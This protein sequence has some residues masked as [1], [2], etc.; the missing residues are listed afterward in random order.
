MKD[1]KQ[2]EYVSAEEAADLL[3]VS[4]PTLYAYVSR[5]GL[6]SRA[7][8]GSRKRRY[9]RPDLERLARGEGAAAPPEETLRHES[10]IT[11]ITENGPYY[12]GQS[13]V[14]LAESASFEDV[15]SL[16]WECDA[17]DVFTADMVRMPGQSQ[18]L[19]GLL[20]DYAGVDRATA[21]FLLLEANDPRS[22]DLTPQG[23][24]RTGAQILRWLAAILLKQAQPEV[25]PIQAFVAKV[26]RLP[27]DHADL[28]RR[29]LILAA[30]HGFEPAAFAV[31]A[32]AS[33]GVT[34]WRSVATGLTVTTG[35]RSKLGRFDA[36][37]RLLVDIVESRD[38]SQTILR[39][40]REGASLPGFGTP[41]YATSDPRG[42]ALLAAC[43]RVFEND[44]E[45]RR[46]VTAIQVAREAAKIEPDFNLALMFI[47]RK[48]GLPAWDS[49]LLVGRSA[50]W[51][52]HA[53]EQYA[54]GETTHQEGV[55]K[56]PLP[57]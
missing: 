23:M 30:D 42:K 20:E 12:R 19:A 22:F 48:I 47:A 15:A 40:V 29:V 37:R 55:Y 1:D 4:V 26:L 53:I 44:E 41:M 35:R 39:R 25:M 49:L 11:L 17:Q 57:E 56:G 8:P 6:R 5:K 28:V 51:I 31:R 38:P 14:A 13:A 52:A 33:T 34:P 32:V 36:V 10:A 9:W 43:A 7:V 24:A 45:H 54:A 18:A 27:G 50:G 21:L 46:L 16:L 3:G 2:A